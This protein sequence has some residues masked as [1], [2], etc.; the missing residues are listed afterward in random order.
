MRRGAHLC[1]LVISNHIYIP[2]IELLTTAPR[3]ASVTN[4]FS[5]WYCTSLRHRIAYDVLDGS[6]DTARLEF[7]RC[8]S[9]T[10]RL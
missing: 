1:D 9:H 8:V 4:I 7:L 10:H 6:T 5:V 2:E 3:Q